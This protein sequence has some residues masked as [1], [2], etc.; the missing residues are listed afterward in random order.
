MGKV[1]LEEEGRSME[2]KVEVR[3]ERNPLEFLGE[4]GDTKL[5]KRVKRKGSTAG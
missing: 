3:L 2:K 1:W 5:K 4:G